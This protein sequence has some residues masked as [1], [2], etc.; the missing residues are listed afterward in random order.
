MFIKHLHG[1]NVGTTDDMP[2]PLP[3]K[4]VIGFL[5]AGFFE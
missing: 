1:A 2:V 3:G 5:F 4:E